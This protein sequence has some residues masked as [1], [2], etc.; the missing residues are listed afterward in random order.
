MSKTFLTQGGEGGGQ[1]D[2]TLVIDLTRKEDSNK[3]FILFCADLRLCVKVSVIH[4]SIF[5]N[6]QVLLFMKLR[7]ML[8]IGQNSSPFAC[9]QLFLKATTKLAKGRSWCCNLQ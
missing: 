9:E 4:A 6:M 1:F 3:K 7:R 8:V 5:A 2:F